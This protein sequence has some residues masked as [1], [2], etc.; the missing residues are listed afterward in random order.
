MVVLVSY[1]LKFIIEITQ[2]KLSFSPHIIS[3]LHRKDKLMVLLSLYLSATREEERTLD[4]DWNYTQ[5][6]CHGYY[7]VVSFSLFSHLHLANRYNKHLSCSH[8]VSS[9]LRVCLTVVLCFHVSSCLI[10]SRVFIEERDNHIWIISSIYLSA[11][12]EKNTGLWWKDF[13]FCLIISLKSCPLF[14]HLIL[15]HLLRK[16]DPKLILDSDPVFITERI[17]ICFSYLL[18]SL[19][20]KKRTWD[21]RQHNYTT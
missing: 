15:S 1:T 18:I 13:S 8:L 14:S 6:K 17:T 3:P 7:P 16:D 12:K 10:L 4:Y 21:N 19:L 5:D 11:R 20:E 2:D 9:A